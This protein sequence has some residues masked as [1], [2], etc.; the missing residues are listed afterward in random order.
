M[1]QLINY[2]EVNTTEVS[3]C[4]IKNDE[5]MHILA[6]DFELTVHLIAIETVLSKRV[7]DNDFTDI[8]NLLR[9][10]ITNAT[11][12][13][14]ENALVSHNLLQSLPNFIELYSEIVNII[15]PLF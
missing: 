6:N 15:A 7:P 1:A 2:S 12:T 9:F 5:M 10:S 4:K 13:E 14:I 3:V 8:I 11:V